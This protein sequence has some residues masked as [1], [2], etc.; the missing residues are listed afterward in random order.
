MDSRLIQFSL[1]VARLPSQATS[2]SLGRGDAG[3]NRLLMSRFRVGGRIYAVYGFAA[4][5]PREP[6]IVSWSWEHPESLEPRCTGISPWPCR[7]GSDIPVPGPRGIAAPEAHGRSPYLHPRLSKTKGR[8]S[9]SFSLLIS[10]LC[11]PSTDRIPLV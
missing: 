1:S 11:F 2:V 8:G 3:Y 4:A 9:G 10:T 7:L 6:G 5:P